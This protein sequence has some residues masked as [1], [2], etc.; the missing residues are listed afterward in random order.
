LVQPKSEVFNPTLGFA[1]TGFF[2][3]ALTA[4]DKIHGERSDASTPGRN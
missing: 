4:W 3:M 2:L 1:I